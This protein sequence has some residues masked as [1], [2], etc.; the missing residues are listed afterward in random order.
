MGFE[1]PSIIS[2]AENMT[3]EER[4]NEKLGGKIRNW[5]VGGEGFKDQG[6]A[7]ELRR[8][9]Q[10]PENKRGSKEW[11]TD[12][13]KLSATL[14]RALYAI[15]ETCDPDDTTMVEGN[16][17]NRFDTLNQK[18]IGDLFGQY[19]GDP[20]SVVGKCKDKSGEAES[21]IIGAINVLTFIQTIKQARSGFGADLRPELVVADPETD[22][23]D[24][25]DL[26]LRFGDI[27]TYFEDREIVRLIQLKTLK[28]S[29]ESNVVIQ[30]INPDLKQLRDRYDVGTVKKEDVAAMLKKA[31]TMMRLSDE[32]A[33]KEDDPRL[34]ID[35]QVFLVGVRGFGS[36]GVDNV[37]GV[38]RDQRIID[39]FREDARK[40]GLIPSKVKKRREGEY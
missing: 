6:Y 3:P 30:R 21:V 17:L 24:K 14:V 11:Y 13:A 27:N 38:V 34:M 37:F 4:I 35:A 16:N 39:N 15:S 26:I 19:P 2:E 28:S 5:I 1:I 25:V 12:Q 36:R 23:I 20:N 9:V 31:N 32:E 33:E 40:T 10:T 8:L 18:L 22:A 29:H 7:D